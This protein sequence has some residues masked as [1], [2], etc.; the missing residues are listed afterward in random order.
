[1]TSQ[2]QSHP[3][4]RAKRRAERKHEAIAAKQRRNR[5]RIILIGTVGA[6]VIASVLLLLNRPE[7]KP[8]ITID[9]ANIPQNGTVL[10]DPNAT[11]HVIEYADYQCPVCAQFGTEVAP[12]LIRDYVETGKVTYE[13]RAFPF[14]GDAALDSPDNES[15]Q[16][17]EAAFCAK[18]Q[19]KFW[20]FNHLLAERHDGENKG[21]FSNDALVGFADEL[22][23]DQEAFST[24]LDSG[25]HQQ[26][27]LDAYTAYQGEGINSTPTLVI[28]GEQVSYTTQGY[29][30]LRRQ[31]DAALA[32]EPLPR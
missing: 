18:D 29:D 9:Y 30:L 24:C 28:N 26:E 20:E 11:V 4:D 8:D 19:G 15:V 13:F 27:V 3:A 7:D 17:A 10:G 5:Q 1:M 23:L 12:Q 25:A 14:L 32:G 2:K 6:V 21:T 31:I 22:G 16:A